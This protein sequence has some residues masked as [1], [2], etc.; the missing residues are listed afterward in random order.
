MKYFLVLFV[1]LFCFKTEAQYIKHD[2]KAFSFL[3]SADKILVVFKY[4]NLTF[5]SDNKSEESYLKKRK[6]RLEND[7]KINAQDWVD[8]Y[9]QYKEKEWQKM[10]VDKL[11]TKLNLS[12]RDSVFSLNVKNPDYKLI[13]HTSWMYLGYS[14]AVSE[15]AKLNI[16]FV[17]LDLKESENV[18]TKL[19][20]KKVTG[21]NKK[22][23][24]RSPYS[25]II[26]VGRAYEKSA[27]RL[28]LILKRF[29]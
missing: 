1:C 20:L 18:I 10:F 16:D 3:K 17:F 9:Y 6:S 28:A 22:N 4:D 13:V 11:N 26:R 7:N 19:H 21:V 29:F 25:H 24:N 12:K 15:P 27:F 8:T 14:S 5:D 2:K 23:D